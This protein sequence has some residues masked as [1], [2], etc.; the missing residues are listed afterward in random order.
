[1][2]TDGAAV[3]IGRYNGK[4]PKL[5]QL[6]VVALVHLLCTA[7]NLEDCAKSADSKVP[8]FDT[9]NHSVVKLLQFYLQ[10]KVAELT[11]L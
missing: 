5:R 6:A 3:N 8:Y 7:H 1:M 2:C 9:F 4:V 11:K 10:K